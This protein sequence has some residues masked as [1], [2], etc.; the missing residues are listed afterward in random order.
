MV[1]SGVDVQLQRLNEA[2]HSVDVDNSEELKRNHSNI[3]TQMTS[4]SQDT[5][6]LFLFTRKVKLAV[7]LKAAVQLLWL[8]PWFDEAAGM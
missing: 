2:F 5:F 3:I 8:C 6:L 1:A 7:K 4:P